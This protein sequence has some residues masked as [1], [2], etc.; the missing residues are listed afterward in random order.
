MRE[1][2]EKVVAPR[3][4]LTVGARVLV[5]RRSEAAATG[6]VVEDYSD[7]TGTAERGHDWAPV[8]RPTAL[9]HVLDVAAGRECGAGSRHDDRFAV[10]KGAHCW[11][12]SPE[13]PQRWTSHPRHMVSR[14]Q[15][16][17]GVCI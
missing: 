1:K 5:R 12:G 9:R 10:T 2:S 16:P 4:A 11:S 8:H 17:D 15:S 3:A 6:A 14:A 7:V 13:T